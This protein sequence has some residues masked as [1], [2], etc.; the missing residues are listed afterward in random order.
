MVL[1]FLTAS[2]HGRYDLVFADAWPGKYSHFE[3]TVAV[4]NV[5]GLLII[6][7]MLPQPN[8]PDGHA[9]KASALSRELLSRPDF[10][11]VSLEWSTGLVIAT[12]R[13]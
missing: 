6:D 10:T 8:W 7:D 4:L 2:R 1:I 13:E 3:L 12:K 9:P 11:A 5:G